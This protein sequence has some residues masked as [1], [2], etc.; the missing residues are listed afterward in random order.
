MAGKEAFLIMAKQEQKQVQYERARTDNKTTQ[1]QEIRAYQV[2]RYG[3]VTALQRNRG[4]ATGRRA[5]RIYISKRS[6]Y[7]SNELTD[8]ELQA[9]KQWQQEKERGS[10]KRPPYIP[11]KRHER[12]K[13]NYY[14]AS[15]INAKRK[16]LDGLIENNFRGNS[17]REV[18][19][20]L[21]YRKKFTAKTIKKHVRDFER[22]LKAIYGVEYIVVPELNSKGT[23]H[24]HYLMRFDGR[25]DY[26]GL[27]EVLGN[28]W[29]HGIVHISA[30]THPE[31]LGAYLLP[32]FAKTEL[33]AGEWETEL[34]S[35]E[36]QLAKAEQLYK[37]DGVDRK[38]AKKVVKKQR[39]KRLP[40]TLKVVRRSRGIEKPLIVK[41][42][43]RVMASLLEQGRFLYGEVKSITF[44]NVDQ[45]TGEIKPETLVISVDHYHLTTKQRLALYARGQEVLRDQEA[46]RK[47][48]DQYKRQGLDEGAY[49]QWLHHRALL[50]DT[51][52]NREEGVANG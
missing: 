22:Q 12:I 46:R 25:V 20:T 26:L 30:M 7:L 9:V 4:V 3:K 48:L 52:E 49:G 23:I 36:G 19:V 1:A 21:T 10:K 37:T 29:T 8:G 6:F 16:E 47:R 31:R 51:V 40:K 28:T 5:E 32:Y 43:D 33:K 50:Y 2:T 41:T 11:D 24:L 34:K 27:Y 15:E 18:F 45:E 17:T 44:N 13:H 38:Q 39:I 42:R 35:D 14:S